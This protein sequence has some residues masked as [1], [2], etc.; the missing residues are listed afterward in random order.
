MDLPGPFGLTAWLLVL[1]VVVTVTGV[2]VDLGLWPG[3]IPRTDKRDG[4]RPP[5]PH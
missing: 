4:Q 3:S 5:P 2:L 1:V